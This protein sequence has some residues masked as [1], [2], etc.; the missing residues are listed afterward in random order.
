MNARLREYQVQAIQSWENNRYRGIWSMATGT[1]KTI[2]ALYAVSSKVSV[3]GVVI[4]VVP[5]QDL[6]DQWALVIKHY[7]FSKNIVKCYSEN[8]KW[9]K[10]SAKSLL[11]NH[12]KPD[13]RRAP[14]L[15]TTA[16][17]AISEDF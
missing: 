4:I 3:N 10:L 13:D 12:L 17:T 11:Q 14:Y 15:I 8:S 2:T 9:R 7:G 5:G 6:V 16:A 1:G